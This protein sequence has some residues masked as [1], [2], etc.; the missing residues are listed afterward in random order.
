MLTLILFEVQIYYLKRGLN[1]V[2]V[3]AFVIFSEGLS[4]TQCFSLNIRLPGSGTLLYINVIM[5]EENLF[6]DPPLGFP[7]Y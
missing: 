4:V 3:V 6:V 2:K 1:E 5:A 7:Q